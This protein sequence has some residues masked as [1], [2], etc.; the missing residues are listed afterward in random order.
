MSYTID[1]IT[2]AIEARFNA[3]VCRTDTCWIWTAT[4]NKHGYGYFAINRVPRMSHRIAWV[5]HNKQDWPGDYEARHLCNNPSC[6]NPAHIVPGTYEENL[7]DKIEHGVYATRMREV[8]AKPCMT[9]WGRTLAKRHSNI[10]KDIVRRK[11]QASIDGYY[12]L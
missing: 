7:A 8:F 2:P 10:G 6:V 12:Y 9:P 4:K 5:I 1:N 11:L 3:K